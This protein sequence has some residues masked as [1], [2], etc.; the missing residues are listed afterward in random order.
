MFNYVSNYKKKLLFPLH[1]YN[2][3]PC[4]CNQTVTINAIFKQ[5]TPRALSKLCFKLRTSH[6]FNSLHTVSPSQ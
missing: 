3:W 5:E 6:V 2:L 4:Q 1:Y